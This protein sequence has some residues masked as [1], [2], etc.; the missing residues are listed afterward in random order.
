[1]DEAFVE[2]EGYL[3][4]KEITIEHIANDAEWEG[5]RDDPRYAILTA[6]RST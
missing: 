2:L 6:K 5:L 1:V 3:A 4:R